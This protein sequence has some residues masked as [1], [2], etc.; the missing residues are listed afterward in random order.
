[1]RR[2][3]LADLETGATVEP[4]AVSAPPLTEAASGSLP[5]QVA[6][7]PV[8]P[9]AAWDVFAHAT[10]SAVVLFAPA[11]QTQTWSVNP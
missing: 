7:D 5:D 3:L 11:S 2:I 4:L 9:P 10:A 8:A 6:P 1:M